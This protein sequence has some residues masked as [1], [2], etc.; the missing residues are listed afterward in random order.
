MLSSSIDW[1]VLLWL[2]KGALHR[3]GT[4]TLWQEEHQQHVPNSWHQA[5]SPR[6]RSALT[7]RPAP[8]LGL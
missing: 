8:G 4:G 7:A 1:E 6:G 3:G 5:A 2:G